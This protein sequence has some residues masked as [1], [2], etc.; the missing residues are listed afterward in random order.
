MKTANK[1]VSLVL[2]VCLLLAVPAAVSASGAY[3]G[4]LTGT[5]QVHYCVDASEKI[6]PLE[7]SFSHIVIR[8]DGTAVYYVGAEAY[9]A[10][11]AFN[12]GIGAGY[13]FSLELSY[14][15]SPLPLSLLYSTASSTFGQIMVRVSDTVYVYEKA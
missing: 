13:M 14:N 2:T 5:W 15:G 6:I 7:D 1:L 11:W 8:A 4:Y 3:D 12:T 10:T 9:E